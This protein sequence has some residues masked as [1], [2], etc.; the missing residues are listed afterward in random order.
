MVGDT[1]RVDG[2]RI[3]VGI[4]VIAQHIDHNRLIPLGAGLVVGRHRWPVGHRPFDDVDRHG[5]RVL[6][7]VG[8]GDGVAQG[9]DRHTVVRGLEGDAIVWCYRHRPD[10]VGRRADQTERQAIGMRVIT[11]NLYVGRVPRKDGCR[12]RIGDRPGMTLGHDAN[13]DGC[14]R[15]QAIWVLDG[16]GECD[17]IARLGIRRHLKPQAAARIRARYPAP[18]VRLVEVADRQ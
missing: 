16:V 12:V 6:Q 10:R 14:R 18:R 8:I 17:D 3:V 13:S 2:E 5:R 7:A 4:V 1:D 15:R 9:V 11:Q